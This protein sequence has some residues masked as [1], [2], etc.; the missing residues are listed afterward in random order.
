[1]DEKQWLRC[2]DP[3]AMLAFLGS[4]ASQRK[5][6]L[7]ACAC[8]RRAWPLLIDVRSR[9]AVAVAERAADG[10]VDG[11]KMLFACGDAV[12]VW[13]HQASRQ[14]HLTYA[15]VDAAVAASSTCDD[16]AFEA[17]RHAS[18]RAAGST[19]SPSGR[20]DEQE[21]QCRLLR[22]VFSDTRTP[23]PS[24]D[25]AVLEWGGGIVQRLALAAYDERQLP[26]GTLDNAR[27]AVLADALEEAGCENEQILGHLRSGGDHVR[28]CWLIDLLLGKE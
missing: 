12:N 7:F 16:L 3:D 18:V 24:L 15:E 8:V 22:D 27:L 11:E 23:L 6:R 19:R 21:A 4:T 5:L 14:E 10:L 20:A 28:G 1:M 25:R 13:E 17:A 26:V 2:T 9:G